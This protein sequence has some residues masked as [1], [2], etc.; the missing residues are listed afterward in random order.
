[1]LFLRKLGAAI[2]PV[3]LV[4]SLLAAES[5]D[6][7]TAV[8]RKALDLLLAEKYPE[9]R[10]MLT[11]AAKDRLTLDFLHDQVG[12]EIHTFGQLTGVG[13][14]VTA[15]DGDNTLV[16]FPVHM[17]GTRVNIQFTLDTSL[18]VVGLYLRPLN[19]ALPKVWQRPSYSLSLIH[20]WWGPAEM[21]TVQPTPRLVI[22]RMGFRLLS[23]TW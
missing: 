18:Q 21:H 14:P 2:A 11:P 20:I 3:L 13:D 10:S 7:A 8:A 9:L 6:K 1:M 17:T 12:G 23:S 16:S 5:P 19:A 4:F 15:K 22:S